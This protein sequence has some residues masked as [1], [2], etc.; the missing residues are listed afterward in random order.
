MPRPTQFL[1]DFKR[2]VDYVLSQVHGVSR[3]DLIRLYDYDDFLEGEA[4]QC[5]S[6][7]DLAIAF[8]SRVLGS[9][10]P[11][12][13]QVLSLA[14]VRFLARQSGRAVDDG[15]KEALKALAQIDLTDGLQIEQWL[16]GYFPD[17]L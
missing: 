11:P 13:F 3:R 15:D 2:T 7:R 14:L 5:K 16:N 9:V 12:Y 6:A 8:A 10:S 1:L 4:V 17:V